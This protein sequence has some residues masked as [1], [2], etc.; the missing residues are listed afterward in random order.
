[1]L[2]QITANSSWGYILPAS[3]PVGEM[4][5]TSMLAL[6][7]SFT[8]SL[9]VELWIQLWASKTEATER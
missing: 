7:K 5:P 4:K 9:L 6:E 8:L 3:H 1:M 2:P